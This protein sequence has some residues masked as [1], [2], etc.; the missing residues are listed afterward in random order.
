[1]NFNPS[2]N[3]IKRKIDV[4]E[5]LRANTLADPE[6][7]KSLGKVSRTSKAHPLELSFMNKEL[8]IAVN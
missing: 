2:L 3:N 8:T 1:M 7:N 5:Y 6:T 4:R